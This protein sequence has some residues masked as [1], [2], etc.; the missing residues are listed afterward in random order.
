MKAGRLSL[1][2][3]M[4]T[5]VFFVREPQSAKS[6]VMPNKCKDKFVF[7]IKIWRISNEQKKV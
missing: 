4:N 1:D 2:N 6:V 5:Y 7:V 3:N